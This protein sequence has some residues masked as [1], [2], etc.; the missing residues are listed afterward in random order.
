MLHP[1]NEIKRCIQ[2][3]YGKDSAR[4]LIDSADCRRHPAS[5]VRSE[6]NNVMIRIAYLPLF[7]DK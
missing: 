2:L 3:T 5:A 1:M 4:H 7:L 6:V